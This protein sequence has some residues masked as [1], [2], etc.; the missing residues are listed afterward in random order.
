MQGFLAP[1]HKDGWKFVGLFAGVSCLLF[2]VSC[3]L[4]LLGCVLTAWCA[5]FFRNPSRMVPQSDGVI[6]SP[7]D[8]RVALIQ[9]VVPPKELGLGDALHKRISIFLNVFDV[10]VNRIPIGGKIK[11]IIY[12][13]GQF[14]NASFDKAS[15][16]NERQTIVMALPNQQDIAFTQIAGLIARRIRCD[17]TENQ[18]VETGA[19][20]GL[21]RFGSRMD[22]YLPQ[23][24]AP[25]VVVGQKAIA[26]ETILGDFNR[27][28][29]QTQGKWM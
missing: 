21:I 4:G 22:V 27:P 25:Q 15:E 26:G 8:G 20:Y 1:L 6:V 10:H 12:H 9:S 16:L 5:Y 13:P 24:V 14:L 19:V 2:I 23:G 18:T 3:I 28:Q 17:V 29:N 11:K 7:A